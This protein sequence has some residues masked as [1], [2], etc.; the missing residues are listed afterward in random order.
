MRKPGRLVSGFK[1]TSALSERDMKS[2]LRQQALRLCALALADYCHKERIV[3]IHGH[4]CADVAHLLALCQ[5]AH[6]P[7]YSLTLH[8]DLEVYGT[9]HQA[10]M[11]EAKFV[12]V[13][14]HHLQQQVLAATDLTKERV[15]VTCMG[16]DSAKLAHQEERRSYTANQLR[17]VTVARLNPVKG[18]VHAMAA[19]QRLKEAGIAVTYVIVGGGEHRE[20]LEAETRARG[21]TETVTFKGSLGEED[22]LAELMRA[23]AFVLPSIGR[24][25]AW[26]VSVMEAMA[27]GLPVVSSIIGATPEMITQ[28]VDGI[29]VER[30]DEDGLTEALLRLAREPEFRRTL[31]T[32]ARATAASRF[33]VR[34]TAGRLIEAIAR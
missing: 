1:Y 6:G 19:V 3:H 21:L 28:N 14:G 4:S 24:G 27:C 16:I 18:H 26:P 9:D 15:W 25:E 20:A 29:L 13:V 12:S 17:I 32:K 31:G 8:G 7:T 34:E 2:R 22:V 23:D 10:K 11:A 5:R 30:G 33:D